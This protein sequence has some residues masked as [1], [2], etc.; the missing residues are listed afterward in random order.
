MNQ[1]EYTGHNSINNLKDIINKEKKTKIL[2]VT[3]KISYEKSGLKDKIENLLE[4]KQLIYFRDYEPNPKLEDIVNGI[5]LFQK[6]K[7]EIIIAAG[8]GSSI[9]VAKLM[10][11]YN[12]INTDD[13][14]KHIISKTKIK[15]NNK[16][17]LIAIPTTAGTGSEATNFAVVYISKQ[18]YSVADESILPEYVILDS[19]YTKTV[20]KIIAASAGIDSLCQAIESYWSVN[21]T[22]ESKQYA[23]K[24]MQLANENIIKAVNQKEE[25]SLEQMLLASNYAGKAIN[26]SKTTA[27]HALSYYITSK[28]NIPHGHAVG[29][30]LLKIMKIN[31]NVN[32]ENITDKRGLEYVKKTIQEIFEILKCEDLNEFEKRFNN[33]MDTIGLEKDITNI[34]DETFEELIKKVNLERLN[35]NPINF[36]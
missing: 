20:P 26:I 30:N 11:Y 29:L 28:Y 21:S 18:K 10:K 7:P 23:K 19:K 6:E 9:D 25:K 14:D 5:K 3:G 8:G 15:T 2:L 32:E 24:A 22:E 17:P 16:V 1:I 35:N 31:Y 12:N 34:T 36:T 4:N 33:I 13:L 27:P